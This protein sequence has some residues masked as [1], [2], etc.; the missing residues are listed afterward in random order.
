MAEPSIGESELVSPNENAWPSLACWVGVLSLLWSL[1]GSAG[2][3]DTIGALEQGGHQGWFKLG[4]FLVQGPVGCATVI[5]TLA[6][7]LARGRWRTAFAVWGA[8]SITQ[9]VTF[10]IL[11]RLDGGGC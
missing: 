11:L 7:G 3:L 4:W 1:L 6:L 9:A 5:V 2:L 8:A 10:L